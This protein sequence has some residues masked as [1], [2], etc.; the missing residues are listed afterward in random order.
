MRGGNLILLFKSMDFRLAPS[1]RKNGIGIDS[2]SPG[3][4]K[5]YLLY[6]RAKSYFRIL[7]F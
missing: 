5:T 2:I 7:W 1:N 4:A 6:R 3:I